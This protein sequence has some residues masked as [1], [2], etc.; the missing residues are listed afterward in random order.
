MLKYPMQYISGISVRRIWPTRG[1][2]SKNS[3]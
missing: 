1:L 3:P 2:C